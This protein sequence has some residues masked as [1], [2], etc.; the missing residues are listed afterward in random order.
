[1]SIR[2]EAPRT[3][4]VP[5]HRTCAVLLMMATVLPGLGCSGEGPSMEA[6]PHY[7]AETLRMKYEAIQTLIADLSCTVKSDCHTVG[8]GTKGCGGT[9]QYLVYS[10]ATV[11]GG[12]LARAVEDFNAYQAGYYAE[13]G[14]PLSDCSLTPVPLPD[15]VGDKCAAS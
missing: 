15:C 10:G 5:F 13:H 7:D 3:A 14:T 4:S 11:D 2:P 1:M 12:A 9:Q 8:V 6:V